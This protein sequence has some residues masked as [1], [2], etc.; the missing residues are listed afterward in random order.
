MV[1]SLTNPFFTENNK[2]WDHF[3]Q[4]KGKRWSDHVRGWIITGKNN[5][6]HIVRYEDLKNDTVKEMKKVVDFLG[7]PHISEAD[8]EERLGEGYNNFYRNHKDNFGHYTEKQKSFVRQQVQDTI[9]TLRKHGKENV[10]PIH[11]YL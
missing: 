6:F 5:P 1:G 10:F 3:V 9:N 2:D 11:Q 8:I 7:F 4:E